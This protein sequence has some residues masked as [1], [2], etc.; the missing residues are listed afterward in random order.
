MHNLPSPLP[1]FSFSSFCIHLGMI[2]IVKS[3]LPPVA[4]RGIVAPS[5]SDKG[6]LVRLPAPAHH[7]PL[8]LGLVY[9]VP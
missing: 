4:Q 9:Y 1:E 2:M 8:V 6:T 5:Q 7:P 3:V